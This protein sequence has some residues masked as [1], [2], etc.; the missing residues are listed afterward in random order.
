MPNLSA[1]F[2]IHIL[3]LPLKVRMCCYHSLKYKY[4]DPDIPRNNKTHCKVICLIFV[5]LQISSSGEPTSAHF[6]TMECEWL[7]S[8]I[9]VMLKTVSGK[10][11]YKESTLR[12]D[13]CVGKAVG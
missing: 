11:Y 6:N 13:N 3:Q 2:S 7:E 10:G 1:L 12:S 8:F 5:F 9:Y 4:I